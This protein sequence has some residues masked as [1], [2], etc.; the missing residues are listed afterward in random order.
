MV[1]LHYKDMVMANKAYNINIL[2]VNDKSH[3][4]WMLFMNGKYYTV[5]LL[6]DV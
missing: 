5:A 6:L 2:Y 4:K 1:N 3:T